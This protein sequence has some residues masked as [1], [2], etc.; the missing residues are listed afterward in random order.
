MS[1]QAGQFADS[2]VV[3]YDNDNNYITKTIITAHEK[4]ENYIEIA[5][6]LESL[7]TGARLNLLIVHSDG[8]SEFGGTLSAVRKGVFEISLFGERQRD[9]RGAA[10]HTLEAEA[11]IKDMIIKSKR[12]TL[13]EPAKVTI[14]NISATGVFLTSP[15]VRFVIGAV[16]QIEVE[17]HGKQTIL[18]GKVVREQQR[19]D[20][21]YSFG[22][23]LIFLKK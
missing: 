11:I 19:G 20:G 1:N 12:Y 18:H 15:E 17:I 5:E 6:G 7:K 16:V 22:C 4:K 8:V 9:A 23:Q 13:R 14:E 10:R 21:T 2:L 3:I